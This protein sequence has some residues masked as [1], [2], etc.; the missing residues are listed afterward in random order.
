M[1]DVDVGSSALLGMDWLWKTTELT[2]AR[3]AATCEI[4]MRGEGLKAKQPFH[5]FAEAGDGNL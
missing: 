5:F 2:R 3:L 1:T 4:E